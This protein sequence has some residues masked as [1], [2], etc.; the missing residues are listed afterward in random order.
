[1]HLFFIII[2]SAGILIGSVYLNYFFKRMF[3]F[4]SKEKPK[5]FTICFGLVVAALLVSTYFNSL[6][7]A[8]IVFGYFALFCLLFDL[9][10]LVY[11]RR[12]PK[13]S[14]MKHLYFGG[15]PA[16]FITAAVMVLGAINGF[17]VV[18]TE[19][20][21][22]TDKTVENGALNIVFIA[23]VHMGVSI[24][25]ENIEGYCAEIEALNPDIVL[26]GG[27][28]FDERT[29][30]EEVE[31]ACRAFGNLSSKYGTYFV[32]GNHE[33]DVAA[34]IGAEPENVAF[35]RE[36]VLQNG[37][38]ILED[39]TVLIDDSFYLVG[40]WDA[41]VG[42]SPMPAQQLMQGLDQE[43]PIIVLEHKPIDVETMA[44][45]GADLYLSGHTHGGQIPPIGFFESFIYDGVYGM[46]QVGDCTMIITSGMGTWNSPIRLGSVSEYVVIHLAEHTAT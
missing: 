25:K 19:Y 17:H 41:D 45:L 12:F 6:G 40:R 30:Q 44:D 35:V 38:H 9:L 28:L 39:E 14:V 36:N 13:S 4:F 27:D 1:M 16:F 43:K 29:T 24:T 34:V 3:A 46:E 22:P 33:G 5:L 11:R 10:G 26:L 8:T 23:D 15:I 21:V 42:A 31:V 37:I 7:T 2:V 18:M 32:W 20:D